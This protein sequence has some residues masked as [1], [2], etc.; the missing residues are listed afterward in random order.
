MACMLVSV[1]SD[2]TAREDDDLGQA[3]TQVR[4]VFNDAQRAQLVEQVAGSLLG[5]VHTDAASRFR[6]LEVCRCRP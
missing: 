1:T 3:G 2:Q 5:G 4:Q 6:L